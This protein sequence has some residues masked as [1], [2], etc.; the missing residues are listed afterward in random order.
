MLLVVGFDQTI[1]IEQNPVAGQ[2]RGRFLFVGH[3]WHQAKWHP[4]RAKVYDL[5]PVLSERGIV[6]C[7]RVG[8]TTAFGMKDSAKAGHEHVGR[9]VGK[10]DLVDLCQEISRRCAPL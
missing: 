1:A 3:A 8:E 6:S 2:E 9:Y 5:A 10:E 7:V 4:G